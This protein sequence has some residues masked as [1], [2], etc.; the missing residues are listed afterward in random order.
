[1]SI[2]FVLC[3][4][5]AVLQSEWCQDVPGRAQALA[6]SLVWGINQGLGCASGGGRE[7]LQ[8]TRPCQRSIGGRRLFER[9]DLM[10]IMFF[11]TSTCYNA[12]AVK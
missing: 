5:D 1:M 12:D 10:G 7:A 6:S 8:P 3:A 9:T 4:Q 2:L 11:S